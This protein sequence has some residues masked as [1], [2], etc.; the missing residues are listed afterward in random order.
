MAPGLHRAAARKTPHPP[1]HL[2]GCSAQPSTILLQVKKRCQ[3]A[4]PPAVRAA[5]CGAP[6]VLGSP[7]RPPAQKAHAIAAMPLQGYIEYMPGTAAPSSLGQAPGRGRGRGPRRRKAH[8]HCHSPGAGSARPLHRGG[9]CAVSSSP[10]PLQR[11]TQTA[12]SPYTARATIATE[13]HLSLS[14]TGTLM[15]GT[16]ETAPSV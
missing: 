6:G 2:L 4:T 16:G 15:W 5:I 1:R 7:P 12:R 9:L 10:L 13:H 8:G 11:A 14:Q 3:E